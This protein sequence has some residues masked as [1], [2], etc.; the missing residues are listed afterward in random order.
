MG[1]KRVDPLASAPSIVQHCMVRDFCENAGA[2]TIRSATVPDS[3]ARRDGAIT[4][5]EPP[6][7]IDECFSRPIAPSTACSHA[8]AVVPLLSC[9]AILV[10][11]VSA[12]LGS[13]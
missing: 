4:I 10:R 2:A 9:I 6:P 5:R 12:I 7:S 3:E 13:P 11:L 1:P 8:L